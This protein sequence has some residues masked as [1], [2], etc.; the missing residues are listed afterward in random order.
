MERE[1]M[2]FRFEASLEAVGA[3]DGA[4]WDAMRLLEAFEDNFPRVGAAVGVDLVAEILEVTF[5]ARGKNL[6]EA[7]AAARH[8]LLEASTVS[9]LSSINLISLAGEPEEAE[10]ALAS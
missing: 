6:N 2:E 3:K 4:D 9:G 10:Q 7:T 8:I 5:S 1:I